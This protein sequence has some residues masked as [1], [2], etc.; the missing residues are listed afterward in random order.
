MQAINV[1]VCDFA[2]ELIVNNVTCEW[3][4]LILILLYIYRKWKLIEI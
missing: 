3:L 4:N 2:S 1:N